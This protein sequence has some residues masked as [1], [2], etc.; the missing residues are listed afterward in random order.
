MTFNLTDPKYSNSNKLYGQE[1]EDIKLKAIQSDTLFED[2]FFPPNKYSLSSTGLLDGVDIDYLDINWIRATDLFKNAEFIK[3]GSGKNDVN[4]GQLGDCWFLCSLA[5]L[6]EQEELFKK[7]VPEEQ[8]VGKNYCG[9][10]LFR[11]WIWGKWIDVVVDD[12]IPVRNRKPIFSHGDVMWS[13]LCEKAFA[14]LHG[15][16]FLLK[17]GDCV[18]SLLCLTGGVTQRFVGYWGPLYPL[19]DENKKMNSLLFNKI[20]KV[21]KTGG[22][23]TATT[24][25]MDKMNLGVFG[26]HA[27]SVTGIFSLPEVNLIKIR[28]PWGTPFEWVGSWSDESDEMKQ[29][30]KKLRKQFKTEEGEWWMDFKDFLKCYTLVEFCHILDNKWKSDD[31]VFQNGRWTLRSPNQFYLMK[32]DRKD[33]VFICLEQKFARQMGDD[34]SI[35]LEIFNLGNKYLKKNKSEK[36]TLDLDKVKHAN[37]VHF[38]NEADFKE[39]S[40]VT[41]Y[42]S[43]ERGGYLVQVSACTDTRDVDFFLRFGSR[44]GTHHVT[45]DFEL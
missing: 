36:M 20:S 35:S 5:V 44:N 7:V 29:I 6:A 27:Y 33:D 24:F 19:E 12:F 37:K 28:N 13:I 26:E 22:L 38:G 15:S 8:D 40:S 10:F 43:L 21:F 17:E 16:Y 18:E 2:E 9:A 14:K 41:F 42:G 11:F 25:L 30:D 34:A 23:V 31:F 32:V 4:Q 1:Y 3:N 45:A 39:L